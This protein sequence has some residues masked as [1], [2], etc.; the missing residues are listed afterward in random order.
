MNIKSETILSA[1]RQLSME[2][3]EQLLPS[4]QLAWESKSPVLQKVKTE[5]MEKQPLKPCPHCKAENP[6]KRGKIKGQQKYCCRVCN[7]QYRENTGTVL[8]NLQKKDKLQAYLE[9]MRKGTSIKKTAKIV[10]ISIQTS[11]DWR[12]K[13][14]SSTAE[15]LHQKLGGEIQCDELELAQSSK[16]ERGLQ[17]PSRKRGNDFKRN[18]KGKKNTTVQVITAIDNHGVKMMQAVETKRL[19][20]QQISQALASKLERNSTLIT[21]E[22]HSYKAF[23]KDKKTITH[24]TFIAKAHQSKT[25][26]KVNLQKVNQ[27]HSELRKFLDRFHGVSTKYLQNYLNWYLNQKNIENLNNQ[28]QQWFYGIVGSQIAYS[29][30]QLTKLNSAIIRT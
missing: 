5:L 23:A 17:R 4:L 19:T 8:Y 27:T 9:E 18:E 16:G 24:K 30:Y 21:D 26:K 14:L 3:Q 10:G 6:L 11:F 28:L 22:H 20:R 13:I 1:F 29:I 25:D 7:K 15:K 12:H 2:Q